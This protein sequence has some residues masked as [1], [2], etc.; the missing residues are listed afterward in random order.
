V[1]GFLLPTIKIMLTR[2]E[3]I[4]ISFVPHFFSKK[5]HVRLQL[6]RKIY[7]FTTLRPNPEGYQ[8]FLLAT[9]SR[10]FLFRANPNCY[11]L[12]DSKFYKDSDNLSAD[13]VKALLIA[14]Q[15]LT[16]Q[17]INRA[18]SISALDSDPIISRRG[19]IPDDIKLLVWERD[20]GKCVK[21]GSNVELQ[22]DH[23]IP[24]A[25]GGANTPENLQVLCGK[26]NRAKSASVA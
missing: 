4:K 3:N 25:L 19:A 23:I 6:G 26:C 5:G 17:R 24:F 8:Q 21:C 7:N 1:V 2:I 11:W 20:H 13:E 16:T 14:R 22:Y 15:K 18:K 12:F 9:K 10:P